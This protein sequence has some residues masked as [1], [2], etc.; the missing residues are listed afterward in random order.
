MAV[1][2]LGTGFILSFIQVRMAVVLT[3][4]KLGL[5]GL[6]HFLL[7]LLALCTYLMYNDALTQRNTELITN[8]V[9]LLFTNDIN[10]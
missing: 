8:A 7:T 2:Y 3:D 10:E 6:V 1:I 4:L 9:I 5:S